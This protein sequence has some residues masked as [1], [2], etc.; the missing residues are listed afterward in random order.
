MVLVHFAIASKLVALLALRTG[1]SY[2][3]VLEVRGSNCG[4]EPKI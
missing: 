1:E 2:P 3:G 4:I